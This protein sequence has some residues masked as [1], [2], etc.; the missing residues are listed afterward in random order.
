MSEDELSRHVKVR[1][2]RDRGPGGQHRNKVETGVVLVYTPLGIEA[3][4]S[5]KRSQL[6]NRRVAFFRLRIELAL[7]H[8]VPPEERI[9][10]EPSTRWT[11]R[12]R[13]KR[14]QVNPNHVDFPALLAE[15]LDTLDASDWEVGPTAE[16]LAISNSQLLKF[17]KSEP[18]AFAKLNGELTARGKR[19]MK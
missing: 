3:A 4:A 6:E 12:V 15:A 11:A 13:G 18:R 2:R 1:F 16:I 5:E 19:P 8:R 7:E 9:S 14:I 17:L 10:S